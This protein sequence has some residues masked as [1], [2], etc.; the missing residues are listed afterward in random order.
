[1]VHAQGEVSWEVSN[2]FENDDGDFTSF[3]LTVGDLLYIPKGLMH[4][5]I[6]KTKRISIS[7]PVA[8]RKPNEGSLKTQDRKYY[9]F[10]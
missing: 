5:A 8:E 7:V 3:D 6:P 4:R 1:L 10:T 2:S 9:D